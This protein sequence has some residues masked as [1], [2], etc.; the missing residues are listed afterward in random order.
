MPRF[1]GR[2]L[3][4]LVL[5]LAGTSAVAAT[6]KP[7]GTSVPSEVLVKIRTDASQNEVTG[8]EH[9][10]D[11]D[12]GERI[13]TVKSGHILRLH[14]R[15][16]NVDALVTA[17]SK[18]PNVEYVEPN[19]RLHL[20]ATPNDSSYAQLWG[21]KNTGQL[22]SGVAGVAGAD[23]NAE[24]AWNVTTGS[25]SIVVGVVD[26]GIDYNHP[27][28]AANV[29]S[30]PGG[31]GNAICAAGTHGFNAITK[32]CNPM[33]DHY[34]GTHVSGT[35]GGVGNNSLGVAGVNWTTSIMGLKFL[36]WDGG[37]TT[38]DAIAAIDFAVQAKIDG[39]NV[40]V[41]SNSWGG[42]GFSKALLDEINKA[43]E[44]DILFVASAGNDYSNSDLYPHYP[45]SYATPNMISVAATD[46]RDALAYFS[47]IGPTTVH[48]G[49]P[50]MNVY[51]TMPGASYGS[52][53]GTSMAAPHV[54]GV[55][56]LVLAQHPSYTTAQV[57]A[58][59]LDNTD[60]I[61][62]LQGK[63]IT[64]GRL[65]AA[66]ALG[67]PAGP[68]F[69]LSVS[70]ASRTVQ[71]GGST[72]YTITITP[73]NGFSGDVALSITG[74]PSGATGSF[75][76]TPATTNSTLTVTTSGSTPLSNST[77]LITATGGGKSHTA[78]ASL[79]VTAPP[80]FVPCPTLSFITRVDNSTP[81][82][83]LTGDFNRDGKADLASANVG[84]NNVSVAL[85]NG[86]GFFQ[87]PVKFAVGT[88]PLSI[89]GADFN[90]DGKIDLVTANS[91]SNNVSILIGTGDGSFQ[92]ATHVA[93]GTSPFAVTTGDFN[94][95]G[96]TDVA[97]ANNGSSN[98]SI[99]LGVGDGTF[100]AAVH[101]AAASGPFSIAAADLNRDG[102]TDLAVAAYNVSK[103][104]VLRG[105][106]NGTFQAAVT[107]SA[108]G[109][110]ASVAAG[111]VNGDG[112]IDLATAN[113][114]TNNVSIL[115]GNGDGTLQA[116]TNIAAGT[117]PYSVTV[118]DLT[119]D[120]K[121]DLTTANSESNNISLMVG[122]GNGTF[123]AAI[124]YPSDY[125]SYGGPNQTILGDFN[126]DGKTDVAVANQY[127]GMAV[128]LNTGT[129]TLNCNIMGGASHYSVGTTPNA[130][131]AGDFNR[132]GVADL[133]VVNS[134][135]YTIS[136][137]LGN[138]DGT[139]TA[140]VTVG[141][142]TGTSSI[143]AGDFDADGK[144]DLAVGNSGS[145]NVSVLRG[146]GDGTFQAAVHYAA[147]T[148]PQ[149]VA[150]GDFDRDGRADLAVANSGSNN[151]SVLRGNG[152]AT[153]QAAVHYG[154]GTS[155][156]GL[157]IGDFNR[158]GILDLAT[159]NSGSGNVSLLAGNAGGTFQTAVNFSVGSSPYAIV[160]GD[161]NR[162]GK[163]D[164]ATAN[165]GS[166]DI[167][168]LLGTGSAFQ[169]AVQYAAGVNPRG[170]TVAD[171]NADGRPD[172]ASANYGSHTV[173][174]LL[175]AGDGSFDA[176][177]NHSAGTGPAAVV[178]GDFNRDGKTDLAVANANSG[179]FSILLATCPLPDLVVAK[180]HA[181]NFTQG[182]IGA[183]YTIT[184][185]N[186]GATP[187]SGL[188]TVTD[189]LPSGLIATAIGGTGWTCTLASLTCT[190]G[191]ALAA[192]ASYPAITLTVNVGSGAASS[193]LNVVNVSGGG[194]MYTIN[195]GA[196]DNATVTQIT[197]LI[198]TS[199]HSGSFS[200]G[201]TGRTYTLVAR[202][203]G[204]L[205]TSGTVTVADT[206]PTGLTATA[207]SGSGWSCT[208]GSLTCTR[209]DAL[210][211]RTN[212]PPITLTVNV[213][214]GA[215][216]SLAN[217]VT[218]S[219]GSET[220]TA[221]NTSVDLTVVWSSQTCGAFGSAVQY[222]TGSDPVA[223]ATGDFNGDGKVDLAVANNYSY[224]VSILLGNGDGTFQ[225]AVSYNVG[226]YP[227]GLGLADLNNDGKTDIV[228]AVTYSNGVAVL[229]GNGNGTFAPPAY[230]VAHTGAYPY[231]LATG[232]FNGDGNV[233]VAVTASSLWVLLGNGNGTLQP[234][235]EYAATASPN[236]V[237]ATE[238]NGDSKIDLIIS[239]YYNSK[240]SVMLG[241]GDGTFQ[242][243]ANQ[244]SVYDPNSVSVGDFNGD[245]NTDAVVTTYYDSNVKILIGAG[246]GTFAAPV[247]Y[248]SS[249]GSY[250]STVD[251][252]N[253]DGKLDI[254]VANGGS[255]G[256]AMLRGNG[257]GTFQPYTF[258]NVGSG[259]SQVVVSDFNGDGKADLA[260]ALRYSGRVGILMN[261]CP[262]LTLTKSHSGTFYS[263]QTGSYTLRVSNSG[264]GNSAGQI[265]VT[266]AL[267][268]GLTAVSMY[269]Y[270]WTCT[271]ETL[272]CTTS[273]SATS[274]GYLDYIYVFVNIA[275]NAPA[276]ITNTATVTGGGDTN[277]ANN[278]A[279]DTTSVVQAPDL[280]IS[281]THSG[282]FVQGQSGTY[283]I[284]VGN[285]GGGPTS[286]TVTVSDYL[287]SGMTATSMTGTGWTCQTTSC[288]RSDALAFGA[289]YPPITLTVN[290]TGTATS[291]TNTAY[292]F[293]GGQPISNG[294]NDSALD[295]TQ[296][297][298]KPAS[299]FAAAASASQV[300][301]TWTTVPYA[302][303][304]QVLRSSNNGP[305][306]VVGTPAFNVFADNTVS[307]NTSYLYQVRATDGVN[308][309]PAS[310]SDI[311]TTII[312]TDDPVMD[313]STRSKA[314]HITELRTAVNAMRALVALPPAAFS[315]P[316]LA[317]GSPIRFVHIAELR[318]ALEAA[319]TGLGLAPLSYTDPVL[320]ST[321]RLKAVHVQQLRSAVK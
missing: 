109:G 159:A 35:I 135:A 193:V 315:D 97:V 280:V 70:P 16:K 152:N 215:A 296:I 31:K 153:F 20:I 169:T 62:S 52:L 181:G 113:F 257:D 37:G 180:S 290:M 253:G 18:N 289:S 234:G 186:N 81:T 272:T 77:P 73:T 147:G 227:N 223:V 79:I 67:V 199:S 88:T 26:T 301:I 244:I 310:L 13:A 29:W 254:L 107:Y 61:S 14:S 167:S 225:A 117:A 160:S 144:L 68:D 188:V 53:S 23:I 261:G 209:S 95:D 162:D 294:N 266:D 165:N 242:A 196:S 78:V 252:L 48:L 72:T 279:S 28:L 2:A 214:A 164:L 283:T 84:T 58:A 201:A 30:N 57:K 267:P 229:L 220:N 286:G 265:S 4:L 142:G 233:D 231:S 166:N 299:V 174:V 314:V 92:T 285:N 34:H 110:T 138:A 120:G 228:V 100:Q 281:K 170:L 245:G 297:L 21:L 185:T 123:L 240:V 273:N 278:G 306:A 232:D 55:A 284:T 154:T 287:P 307:P 172:L 163:A 157:A 42:G 102:A 66:R 6:I 226:S 43:S 195:N 89:A 183:T 121:A 184:V 5:I 230:Y 200:Q 247:A 39:V 250:S 161:F 177:G 288:T 156:R 3:I 64:N 11:A 305:F 300:T 198:V 320:S 173:S 241:N 206:L 17:L 124:T 258:F 59:I 194:E 33:D 9:L 101:Y 171:F 56:A 268:S 237:T 151:V 189:T 270:G 90:G 91:G 203:A 264:M 292:V 85:G 83:L 140:G 168:V 51:S 76:P 1:P 239:S 63:V 60:P 99:L 202:N 276:S 8:I 143:A 218:V 25:A 321:S 116:A 127:S 191:D 112:K 122:N 298:T 46:N 115:L 130:F 179:T 131:A 271:L 312:F 104:A 41:L 54:S 36:D 303:G 145:N 317:D 251:D 175:G 293:G 208:L 32:T 128:L 40:R 316:V 108:G 255:N 74:L 12:Q 176:S 259:P 47:N 75:T 219:G 38:A 213:S 302:T 118:G 221:N 71:R 187:T 263:G 246:N 274:G 313:G 205:A 65:N 197:D 93:A 129:C 275:P 10:A 311:A 291:L 134:G 119:N 262:D 94:N 282:N 80:V 235:V 148:S 192:A 158:D 207:I 260:A 105:N 155:P 277:N 318:T 212:Y 111:D 50:G 106:G 269:G 49:A 319:R 96:K 136:I 139:F 217:T 243:P 103:V 126:G 22:I 7:T 256:I 309:G 44:N 211:A 125:Y 222:I 236:Y 295:F 82:A 216:P 308:N 210:G 150:I 87:T 249:Y 304:Y 248:P 224:T 238:L 137:A 182:A 132:D 190:R 98:V 146:N 178:S 149:A 86:N 141:A 19:Y 45:S 24:G 15:S 114:S 69:T 204:G 133:A 27:D